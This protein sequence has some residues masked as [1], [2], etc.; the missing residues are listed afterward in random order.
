MI[1]A[2]RRPGQLLCQDVKEQNKADKMET[3][4]MEK[5]EENEVRGQH[6]I[7]NNVNQMTDNLMTTNQEM[8]PIKQ[9]K[10]EWDG[11][12]GW[13]SQQREQLWCELQAESKNLKDLT[14]M[15][16]MENNSLEDNLLK[17]NEENSTL[18]MGLEELRS[19]ITKQ[20]ISLKA[21]VDE[22]VEV[23][24]TFNLNLTEV[25]ENMESL[26]SQAEQTKSHAERYMHLMKK[27]EK[28]CLKKKKK[29]QPQMIELIC[30]NTVLRGKVE[31]SKITI[32]N[33][34]ARWKQLQL[35][36]QNMNT[37]RRRL[38]EELQAYVTEPTEPELFKEKLGV[39]QSHDIDNTKV[40]YILGNMEAEYQTEITIREKRLECLVQT[41]RTTKNLRKQAEEKLSESL[42]AVGKKQK[43]YTNLLML[44]ECKR[45]QKKRELKKANVKVDHDF[46]ATMEISAIRACSLV[47]P[48]IE[49]DMEQLLSD[50]SDLSGTE[51]DTSN[52]ICDASCD[53]SINN[54]G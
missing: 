53:D 27:S 10:H 3:F 39:L 47:N 23:I 51:S 9:E 11:S 1:K 36:R 8:I 28:Y 4:S 45:R 6:F 29:L 2:K 40:K 50:R 32:N 16:E 30:H 18:Q 24:R 49:K 37:C 7:N 41:V 26:N 52:H 5:E 19:T 46:M 35:H 43:E 22:Q 20:Q 38:E 14:V 42:S 15:N 12:Q 34:K 54:D 31:Q 21:T 13:T 17:H 25:K 48:Q 44:E 33:H